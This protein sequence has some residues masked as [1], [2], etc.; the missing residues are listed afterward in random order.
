[1]NEADKLLEQ[2]V[3]DNFIPEVAT[4]S[5]L[6]KMGVATVHGFKHNNIAL[7]QTQDNQVKAWIGGKDRVETVTCISYSPIGE[8]YE[9]CQKY[10]QLK[11]NHI[12]LEKVKDF[13]KELDY[14]PS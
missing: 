11:H 9:K 12:R 2:Y 4:W 5:S 7:S 14:V 13:L 3:L 1:M 6:H 10:A 8:M